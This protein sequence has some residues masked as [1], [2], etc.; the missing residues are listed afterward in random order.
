MDNLWTI[1][2][3]QPG[4]TWDS[5]KKHLQWGHWVD[6]WTKT[7]GNHGDSDKT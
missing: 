4:Y 1:D 6:I 5:G 3:E 7:K 2:G